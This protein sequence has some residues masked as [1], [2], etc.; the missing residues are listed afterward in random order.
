MGAGPSA[1]TGG[2]GGGVG[3]AGMTGTTV[4][5]GKKQKTYG[6]AKDAKNVLKEG[7][8]TSFRNRKYF[9]KQKGPYVLRPLE[10]LFDAGSKK[11]RT[12]FTDKVLN[13]KRAKS[14]IGYTQEEFAKLSSKK[15]D[16]VYSNYLSNRSSN[17][18]DAYGN[19]LN[20]NS[21]PDND[22]TNVQ[23]P[24]P[25]LEA[26]IFPNESD[27]N[28]PSTSLDPVPSKE[29]EDDIYTR[30]KK[31]KAKGRSMMTLTSSKGVTDDKLILG[32]RSLLG[33]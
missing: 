6:T 10:P 16:S 24:P 28:A 8:L 7:S 25:P 15:Q 29:D 13:S 19:K 12:F 27:P 31:S 4:V 5:A 20:I 3:P 11:T 30:R 1:S 26:G 32:K 2:G 22:P 17:K 14:N 23:T 33:S 18:T 21:G 9:E